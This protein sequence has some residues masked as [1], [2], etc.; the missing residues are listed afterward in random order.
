MTELFLD[1]IQFGWT[2][3][4]DKRY[5]C[6]IN[7]RILEHHDIGGANTEKEFHRE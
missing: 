4:S 7:Y 1:V 6:S 3:C 5:R 2:Q